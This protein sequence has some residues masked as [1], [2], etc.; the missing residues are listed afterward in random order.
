MRLVTH[1]GQRGAGRRGISISDETVL[2][3]RFREP[4]PVSRHL[5]EHRKFR[6][7]LS[8]ILGSGSYFT[9]HTVPS[10]LSWHRPV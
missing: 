3:S 6:D 1:W 9:G 2:E 8:L 4:Q 7:L 10:A 5:A